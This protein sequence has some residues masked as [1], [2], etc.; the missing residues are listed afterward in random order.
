[1][2]ILFVSSGNSTFGISPIV[3]LQGESIQ[4]YDIE[5]DFHTINKKGFKGYFIEIFRLKRKLKKQNYSVVHAHYGLS[6]IVATFTGAKPIV[7][8][9]MGSDVENGGWQLF[10]IKL[11]SKKRWAS[12]ITKSETL[13]IKVGKKNCNVL[14]NGVN[15]SDF[16]PEDKIIARNKLGLDKNKKYILFAA[17]PER[18]EK[19]FSLFSDSINRIKNIKIEVLVLKNIPHNQIA[20]WMNAADVV[21]L[22]SLWEGSPNVIK[23]AMACNRPIVATNV[24]DIK[25]LFGNEEGHYLS[26]FNSEEFANNII[27]AINFSE[28]HKQTNGR[29]RIIELELSS[30]IIAKKIINIYKKIFNE[31]YL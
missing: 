11:F 22:S 18:K 12:T 2:K 17:N 3:K 9:L 20:T 26:D 1:M 23:E 21:T 14:P 10:L 31:S 5:L 30:D 4:N 27:N 7:V 24:G 25:W 16:A 19:N 28:T 8:S 13:A 15:L 6:A 29:K